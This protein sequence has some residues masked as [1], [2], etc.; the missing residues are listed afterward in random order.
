MRPVCLMALL[1]WS[2]CGGESTRSAMRSP[3]APAGTG[4][5]ERSV[6]PAQQTGPV[7]EDRIAREVRHELV[8]LPY[9]GVFDNL[10]YRVDGGTVTLSGA[11]TRPILKSDAEN[12]VKHVAGVER[13]VNDVRVLPLS[14]ADDKL[15]YAVFRAIYSEPGL[16][17][18]AVQAVPPIHMIVE[19]GK[20][21]L[22]GVVASEADKNLA[23]MRASAVEGVVSVQNH[24][25]VGA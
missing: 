11:V 9:Y 3:P 22:E 7:G 13:V 10:A 25:H 6:N 2:A 17:R 23:Y 14:P 4:S 16:S 8:M 1:V 15:R 5:A 20:V 24:L 19:N 18:Y 12:V 21:A